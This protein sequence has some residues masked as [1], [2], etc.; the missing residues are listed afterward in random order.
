L[1]CENVVVYDEELLLPLL[2]EV[3]KLLMRASI[4]EVEDL[5]S[6]VHAKN[7]FHTTTTNA[8]TYK[9]L[10]SRKSIGF[11]QYPI[12]IENF[13]YAY[14]SGAKNKKSFQPLL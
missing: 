4:E 1:G 9:D 3:A 12:D 14:L 2:V 11:Y 6:Q 5:Q 13:K 8:N 7:M 10:A